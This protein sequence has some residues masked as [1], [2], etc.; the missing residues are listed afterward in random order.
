[1]HRFVAVSLLIFACFAALAADAAEA[2]AEV[3]DRPAPWSMLLFKLE[4]GATGASDD[5]GFMSGFELRLGMNWALLRPTPSTDVGLGVFGGLLY[6]TS[7]ESTASG[8]ELGYAGAYVEIGQTLARGNRWRTWATGRGEYFL[9]ATAG[10]ED[11]GFGVAGRLSAELYL[12]RGAF[13]GT[14]AIGVYAEASKRDMGHYDPIQITAGL[15]YRTPLV[16]ID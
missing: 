15:T 9:A 12:R 13:L 4:G 11:A 16:L 8:A 5:E 7:G 1:M 14:H 2:S 10:T 6:D 3:H